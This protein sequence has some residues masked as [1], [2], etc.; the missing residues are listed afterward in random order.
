MAFVPKVAIFR[1][2]IAIPAS[3]ARV[4]PLF[5]PAGE[6]LWVPQWN[7]EHIY[8]QGG[9]WAENQVFR[10][11][12]HSGNAIGVVSKL[13]VEECHVIY[14]RVE[15][16]KYVAKVEVRVKHASLEGSEVSVV[17]TYIGLTEQGNEEI[18]GMTSV[19]YEAKMQRWSVWL[20]QYLTR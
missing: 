5:S 14:F 4:F 9:E 18:R 16:S 15:P 2:S 1:G 20:T 17:Y 11:V 13:E 12:E 19:S 6:R 3:P 10:T 8:P 7:P